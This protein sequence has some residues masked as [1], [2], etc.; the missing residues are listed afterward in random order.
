MKIN[1]S[2]LNLI[3]K[4]LSLSVTN[5]LRNKFLSLATIFVIGIIIFIF[6]II[7][8]I[9]FI[10]NDSISNLSKKIDL[11]VYVKESTTAEQAQQ[12]A[13]DLRELPEVREV[14]YISKDQ[15]LQDIKTSYPEIFQAFEKYNLGNPLPASINI[16]TVS[17]Q[18]HK[19]ITNFL[20]NNTYKSLL[21]NSKSST[22][23]ES[24]AIMSSVSKN[25]MKLSG[26]TH[27]VIFWLII[28]FVL[29]GT[30]I[31]LNAMQ[32]T[33]YTRKKE[34]EVMKLV[35]ASYWFIR[36]PFILEGAIYGILAV[37]LS[38][39][40]FVFLSKSVYIE[41]LDMTRFADLNLY[42]LLFIE[43]II[44]MILTIG[45]SVIAVHEHLSKRSL[46]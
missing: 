19:N 29:G 10:A 16:I 32:I 36:L 22:S 20:D 8:A 44:T 23:E 17:P 4:A 41:N 46:S 38:C 45:S 35:G 18:S 9:N 27:Q 30:L 37:L 33:I 7:L 39:L 15:A 12:I 31:T 14:T 6:N 21:S 26:F 42:A 24:E 2:N 13:R 1:P 34:I 28:V 3:K 43:L 40:M 5:V 25:L 11:V